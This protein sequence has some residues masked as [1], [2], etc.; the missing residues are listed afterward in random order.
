MAEVKAVRVAAA[1]EVARAV[2]ALAMVRRAAVEAEL[3]AV[4]TATA[5]AAVSEAVEAAATARV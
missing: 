2:S 4:V 1:R 3:V 5:V